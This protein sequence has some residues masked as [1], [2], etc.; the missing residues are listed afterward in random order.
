MWAPAAKALWRF[1]KE[2]PKEAASWAFDT[3]PEAV[4]EARKLTLDLE[5]GVTVYE[6]ERS[7][8]A[9]EPRPNEV[10]VARTH[11]TTAVPAAD[12]SGTA[13]GRPPVEAGV[14]VARRRAHRSAHH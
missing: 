4:A 1:N 14:E 5:Y 3:K 8:D 9:P 11:K 13:D 2:G 6:C 12:R 10:I 7:F